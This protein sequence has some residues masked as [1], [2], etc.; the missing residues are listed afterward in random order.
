MEAEN[1]WPSAFE[2]RGE[3]FKLALYRAKRSF[4]RG[5]CPKNWQRKW[6]RKI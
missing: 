2:E 4:V 3:F 1:L 6:Q 5:R